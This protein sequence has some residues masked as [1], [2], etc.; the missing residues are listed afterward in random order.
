MRHLRLRDVAKFTSQSHYKYTTFFAHTQLFTNFFNRFFPHCSS[1]YQQVFNRS[2][3]SFTPYHPDNYDSE[4]TEGD[5]Y[6]MVCIDVY[7]IYS[8]YWIYIVYILYI[9]I[10]YNI[11]LLNSIRASLCGDDDGRRK[12]AVIIVGI[13]GS[14]GEVPA[15]V[16]YALHDRVFI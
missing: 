13:V 6:G 16:V 7:C 10:L 2:K 14:E 12:I 8:I 1:G 15:D 9:N 5:M 11:K 3:L 4:N